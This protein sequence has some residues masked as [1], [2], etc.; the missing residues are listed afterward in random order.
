MSLRIWAMMVTLHARTRL[1][2]AGPERTD[3]PSTTNI[4]CWFIDGAT[5]ILAS[6]QRAYTTLHCA[7]FFREEVVFIVVFTR[8]VCVRALNLCVCACVWCLDKAI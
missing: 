4:C 6:S 5:T 2:R 7:R 3:Q 8:R 1:T